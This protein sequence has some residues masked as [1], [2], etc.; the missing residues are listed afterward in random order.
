MER[1]R[2]KIIVTLEDSTESWVFETEGDASEAF[3]EAYEH[4][5]NYSMMVDIF[6]VY[7]GMME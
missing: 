4:V 1:A 7:G 3:S 2:N 6:K 5:G